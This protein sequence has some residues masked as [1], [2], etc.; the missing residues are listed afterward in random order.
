MAAA[1]DFVAL[2]NL[3]KSLGFYDF[4][5]PW[6]LAFS[7]VFGILDKAG[8]FGGEKGKNKGVEAIISLVFAFYVTLF[9]PY[10]G[11]LSRFFSNL[12]GGSILVLSGILVS[13]LIIGIFGFAP[14]DMFG[15]NDTLGKKLLMILAVIIA[16][17]LLLNAAGWATGLPSFGGVGIN[18]TEWL[19]MII[20]FGLIALVIWAVVKDKGESGGENREKKKE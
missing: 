16:V 7:I 1:I 13:L 14:K 18:P 17:I 20:F 19:T 9:T 3:L 10:P 15:Q 8:I 2:Q 11:F 6:L 12:F 5:L 4:V